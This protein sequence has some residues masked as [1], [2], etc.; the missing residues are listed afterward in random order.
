MHI[1]AI[2]SGEYGSQH[3]Q[4]IRKNGPSHWFVETWRA[5]GVFPPVIDYPEDYLPKELPQVDLIL[6]FGEHRGIAELIPD[7]AG[8]TGAGAVIAPVDSEAWLPRGLAQQLRGWLEKMGVTCVTP[9]PL[10]SLTEVDFGVTRRRRIVYDDP[11]IAEF[12]RY[13]GRPE[14]E[15][16]ID[17]ATRMITS[18]RVK[19]DA[20]CGCA[21]YVAEHLVDISINDA[22]EKSGLLH[23]HYPCLASMGKDVDFDDTLMHVSGNLL[24]DSIGEQVKPYKQ[25][26]YIEPGIRSE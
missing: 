5:P 9:K 17:P 19:R 21:R 20:V 13:F 6:H 1:L 4:N 3:V 12:A 26:Q 15:M 25:I 24:R 8:M 2:I 14:F 18:V 7:M 23:H 16:E 10:C 11:R 22:E